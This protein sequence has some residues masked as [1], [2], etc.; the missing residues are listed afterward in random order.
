MYPSPGIRTTKGKEKNGY[1]YNSRYGAK[2]HIY[3]MGS[4]KGGEG[5]IMRLYLGVVVRRGL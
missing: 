1:R 3:K 2:L 4:V 5:G